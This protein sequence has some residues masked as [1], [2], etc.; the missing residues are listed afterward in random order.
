MTRLSPHLNAVY[1]LPVPQIDMADGVPRARDFD[2]SYYNADDGLAETR[3]VFLDGNDLPARMAAADHLTIAETGF[4]T[5]LN[6]LA[7]M[8]ALKQYPHLQIDYLSLEASPLDADMMAAAHAAFPAVGDEASGLRA[9]LP[10]RWPG[11]HLVIL[12]GGRVSLHLHYG[13]AGDIL[14]TL[15]ISADCWFLDGFAPARNPSLWTPGLLSQIGR[16]TADGG[17]FASFTAAGDVRRGLQDAGFDVHKAAGFG[18]KRDMIRGSMRRSAA[19]AVTEGPKKQDASH[20]SHTHR[21]NPPG[22]VAIIGAGIAGA[23]V[24]AGLARRGAEPL[25]ID[26]ASVPASAAS[27]NRAALQSPRL[28]VDHNAMSR[29]SASCLSFAARAA[30]AAGATIAAGV[31]A[32]DAPD[33]M[34]ARHAIFRQQSWPDSLL[35]DAAAMQPAPPGLDGEAAGIFFEYGRAIQPA[36]LVGML[37]GPAEFVGDF[38]V[39][40]IA[41]TAEGLTLGAADGRHLTVDAVVLSGG[42]SV[43]PLLQQIDAGMPVEVTR[44]QVS[45]VP[46][47]PLSAALDMGVSFGGYLTP[48]VDGLHELGATFSRDLNAAIDDAAAHAHNV[49]LLPTGLLPNLD[50][51]STEN[52][53]LRTSYR[54]S[55]AD[56]RPAM[57]RVKDDIWM[58]G[59]LG[60][61]GFTLAPLLGD[62]LAAAILGRPTPLARDQMAG[63][64]AARYLPE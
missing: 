42:A 8:A 16:L 30:D 23:S 12:A 60:A 29:L 34:A 20:P 48:P 45:H 46:A 14:P 49:N 52:L 3:H 36:V 21:F 41:R 61:R 57:G 10:P 7:V 24:A 39:T 15:D 53:G 13:D 37:A 55:L 43:G 28:S 33:R 5:G 40:S 22:R 31:L 4:G 59:G 17:S 18:R 63:I 6:L 2:D 1:D 25:L 38:A 27:G 19:A 9:A 44:G 54:A 47:T 32:L 64:H 56:R 58:L 51:G 62:A 35:R 26:S 11:Y 50:A